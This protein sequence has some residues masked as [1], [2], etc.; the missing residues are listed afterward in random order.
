M[1]TKVDELVAETINAKEQLKNINNTI[2]KDRAV[3]AEIENEIKDKENKILSLNNEIEAKQWELESFDVMVK[4]AEKSFGELRDS[5]KDEIK[6]LSEK[7]KIDETK[8]KVAIEELDND[9]KRLSEK[10]D[11]LKKEIL[12]LESSKRKVELDVATEIAKMEENKMKTIEK[13]DEVDN[14]LEGKKK[15]LKEVKEE[16][17]EYKALVEWKENLEGEIDKLD[18]MI[19]K[20]NAELKD[21][22]E[23]IHLSNTTLN[24]VEK[25]IKEKEFELAKLE[26]ECEWYVKMKLEIKDKKDELESKE[27][28]LRKRFEEAWIKF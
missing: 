24:G 10:R 5:Y 21:I 1:T 2:N 28:Y 12:D 11:G 23:N 3:L 14:K 16:V 19:E 15:E 26:K 17:E 8:L 6:K 27:K 18:Q 25:K 22:N 4:D 20:K 13:I 7:K 9:V